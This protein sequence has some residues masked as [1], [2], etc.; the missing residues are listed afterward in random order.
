MM[1]DDGLEKQVDGNRVGVQ[2]I[3]ITLTVM[4]EGWQTEH[5]KLAPSIETRCLYFHCEDKSMEQS[6]SI[7]HL[8]SEWSQN[9]VLTFCCVDT[10]LSSS[11][12]GI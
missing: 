12:Q 11:L 1:T 8:R 3:D 10:L 5:A 4:M 9:F 6:D 7:Y 2:G